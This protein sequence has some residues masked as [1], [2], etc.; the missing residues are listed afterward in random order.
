MLNGARERNGED[1]HSSCEDKIEAGATSRNVTV[2]PDF[3]FSNV[4]ALWTR[5]GGRGRRPP[6]RK[7]SLR[8]AGADVRAGAMDASLSA[9]AA[10]ARFDLCHASDRDPR[11]SPA[12]AQSAA[13]DPRPLS[14]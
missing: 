9:M 8:H 2:Q 4:S 5:T 11:P 6:G 3:D 12:I 14:A 1:R 10:P 7:A 13:G